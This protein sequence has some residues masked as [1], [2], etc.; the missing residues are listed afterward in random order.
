MAPRST[1]P[2]AAMFNPRAKRIGPGV[3]C[4]DNIR[5]RCRID[6][7][8]D[9]WVWSM[10]VSDGGRPRSALTPR[11]SVPKG[12]LSIEHRTV[13]VPRVAWLMSGRPLAPGHVVWRTCGCE[14]CVNPAHLQAGTKAEEGAW[15]RESGRR[16][17]DPRRAAVN[18]RNAADAQAVRPEAVRAI[19][20][21]VDAGRL[22]RDVAADFELHV[23][24]ISKIARGLHVHQRGG[25]RQVRGASVFAMA[26]V[27]A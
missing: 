14:L 11:V 5:E 2:I 7:I 20:A 13:S 18:T 21:Q 8:T 9:C 10:A 19:K 4:L 15:M 6:P 22:Q 23:A 3:Y 16:R 27:T 12:V 24:T 26:E 25:G 1:A 17:G